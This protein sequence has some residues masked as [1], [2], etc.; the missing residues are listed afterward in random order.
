[1]KAGLERSLAATVWVD[2]YGFAQEL[3]QKY[4]WAV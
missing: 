1:M 2:K 4:G 3:F